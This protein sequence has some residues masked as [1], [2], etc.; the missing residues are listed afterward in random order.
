MGKNAGITKNMKNLI[1][2]LF[3]MSQLLIGSDSIA[4][5]KK[6]Q[7]NGA[8]TTA[9]NDYIERALKECTS[10][11]CK[12]IL[13]Y[14]NTPGGDLA[15]TRKIVTQIM[16]SPIPFL[17]YLA[18][19]GAQA[20]SAGAII[21]QA[22]HIAGAA[23]GTNIGAATPVS[24]TGTEMPED[25]R[26]KIINDTLSWL[27]SIT[28]IR[29]RNLKFSEEI[30]R[31]AK[32]V[33]SEEALKLGALDVLAKD[34]LEF[35]NFAKSKLVL[36]QDKEKAVEVAELKE[37]LPDTRYKILDLVSDPQHSYLLFMG[38]LAL[39]YF[40]LTHP[41]A[42][43]PGVVGALGL[44]LS[45]VG[46][47]KLDVSWGGLGLIVLG[48]IFLI[49]EAFVP[50]FG[51]LGVGGII[52]FTTGGFLLFEDSL[53]YSIPAYMIL[54][55]SFVIGSLMF[56]IAIMIFRTRS[57]VSNLGFDNIIG[58]SVKV[59]FL[60]EDKKSGNVILHGERWLF[61]CDTELELHQE[62]KII[63]KQDLV[64]QVQAVIKA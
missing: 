61:E 41:G 5:T 28:K 6:L 42:I 3:M 53:Y 38:S 16:N 58:S 31:D 26:K 57:V 9:T 29:N 34:Q 48:I 37:F 22:C 62:V 43:A 4:I 8:I 10:S 56:A 44:I 24:A 18:P 50:S 64:L 49:A 36:I 12:S 32:S 17:C 25:L 55:V 46:F 51:A 7:V 54:S 20:G 13:L 60:K 11:N 2:S 14:I 35:L 39:L 27:E 1:L 33:T 47:Q 30:I 45:L 21:M 52:A 59:V 23:P 40:E 15:S 63:G 19:S